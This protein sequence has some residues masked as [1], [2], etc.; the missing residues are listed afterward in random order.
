VRLRDLQ[1]DAVSPQAVQRRAEQIAA[2]STAGCGI[3][4]CKVFLRQGSR[5]I[6]TAENVLSGKSH[7]YQ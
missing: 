6:F 5:S 3:H 1:L 2:P 7:Y 4:D